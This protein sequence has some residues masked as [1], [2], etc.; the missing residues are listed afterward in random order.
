MDV[1][2]ENRTVGVYKHTGT[3]SKSRQTKSATT[4]CKMQQLF[5]MYAHIIMNINYMN[6]THLGHNI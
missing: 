4:F 3:F 5:V 2:Y 1:K 6:S